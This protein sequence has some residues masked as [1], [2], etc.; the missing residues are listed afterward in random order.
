[1]HAWLRDER[2]AAGRLPSLSIRLVL[3]AE[4][5]VSAAANL[6]AAYRISYKDAFAGSLAMEENAALVAGDP[7]M[8][9]LTEALTVD[10]IG[11]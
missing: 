10:R 3:S 4:E 11:R 1:M 5:D 6:K 7:E 8:R 9:H 2:P